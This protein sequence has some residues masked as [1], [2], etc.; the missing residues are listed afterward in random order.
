MPP[1]NAAAIALL[2]AGTGRTLR[3]LRG[4]ADAAGGLAFS[5]DDTMVAAGGFNE[6]Q[7]LVWDVATGTLLERIKTAEVSWAVAFA[8]DGRTLYTGGDEGILRAY[9]LTGQ[10]Q[11]LSRAPSAPARDYAHILPSGDGKTT[12]YLWRDAR[13]S[14]ASFVDTATGRTTTPANLGLELDLSHRR[15]PAVWRPDGARLAVHDT[16]R[17]AVVDA[18]S[19]KVLEQ[20]KDLDV[21][22]IAYVGDQL[23]AGNWE[24][25]RLFEKGL[26]FEN[27]AFS[28]EAGCCAAPSSDGHTVVLFEDTFDYASEHWTRIRGDTGE[29]LSE[30]RL[31]LVLNYAAYAPNRNLA[32]VTGASGEVYTI[33]L[34]TAAVKRGPTT[35]H[36]GQGLFVR[37]SPDGSKV[38]SG[39]EDGTVSLWDAQTL[40]L[41]GT[42]SI[43][44]GLNAPVAAIPSFVDGNDVVRIAA[45][46]GKVYRWDTRIDHTIAHACAMAGRNLTADEWAQ[47][48][49]NRPYEKTCS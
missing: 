47:A 33:D 37:F 26:A 23:M 29:I 42:V 16:T 22:S 28:R 15:M 3:V 14:W 11:Y 34:E 41:L 17:V 19:G 18:R 36:A 27:V 10:R 5:A 2:D 1:A 49:G 48:F 43:A 20:A 40:D 8:P 30:G 13:G 9:D 39:G 21:S 25:Y 32:A 6:Q 31:P 24:G 35:G 38:V 46:D 7:V 44:D 12:A 45:Y 4:Q